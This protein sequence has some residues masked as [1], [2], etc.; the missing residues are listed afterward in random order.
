MS[1]LKEIVESL[2]AVFFFIDTGLHSARSL[3]GQS[4]LKEITQVVLGL[5]RDAIFN[6]LAALKL[7]GRIV[8]AAAMTAAKIGHTV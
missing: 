1:V 7:P 6:G 5:V 2:L 3:N 4:H 8:V